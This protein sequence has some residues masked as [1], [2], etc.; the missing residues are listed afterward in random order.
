MNNFDYTSLSDED[1]KDIFKTTSF[2]IE[3][4][5]HQFIT[6]AKNIDC[7]ISRVPLFH[8]IGTGKT[9]TALWLTILWGVK[10]V[11]VVCT[12]SAFSSW[13]RDIKKYTKY[14]YIFLQG[15]KKQRF[16][17]L[18][19]NKNIYII[20]YEGLKCIYGGLVPKSDK[21][22][23]WIIDNNMFVDDFDCVIFDEIHKCRSYASIQAEIAYQLSLKSKYTIGMTGTPTESSLLDLWNLFK[24]IDHGK[25]LGNNFFAFRRTYF[26]PIVYNLKKQK[27]SFTD[28][29]PIKDAEKHILERIAPITTCFKREEC[30]DIPK[31]LPSIK[32]ILD[33][34]PEQL[35]YMAQICG[36]MKNDVEEGKLTKDNILACNK[37]T[38]L[39][40]ITGGFLYLKDGDYRTSHIFKPNPK[41]LALEDIFEEAQEKIVVF[42]QFVEEGR[43]LEEWARKKKIEFA[44]IRGEIK[45]KM[46]QYK[47]F[48]ED[49]NTMFLFGH[50]ECASESYDMTVSS[51]M[52][53]Y[54]NSHSRKQREQAEGRIYR[55]GQKKRS[56]YVDLLIKNSI[57]FTPLKSIETKNNLATLVFEFIKNFGKGV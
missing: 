49:K 3:P 54:S 10:K 48:I 17:N 56:M 33:P 2:A 8:D 41:I 19:L 12:G 40:Q 45:D 7:N 15:D 13:E 28:W 29:K 35:E 52:V 22:R 21:K 39:L 32:K 5:R 51:L 25:C 31:K 24:I 18:N 26:Y 42:H 1:F 34:T 43:I 47:K 38:K 9:L 14:S 55:D 23:K 53:F 37:T 4:R 57:D 44:S 36:E 16:Y 20:N 50:P 46:G 27:R 6:L 30:L 11:L